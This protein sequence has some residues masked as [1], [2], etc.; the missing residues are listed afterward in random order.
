[1][2][3]VKPL[4]PGMAPATLPGSVRRGAAPTRAPAPGDMESAVPVCPQSDL[5]ILMGIFGGFLVVIGFFF[6]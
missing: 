5:Q 1:M 3:P 4:G 2:M 6:H